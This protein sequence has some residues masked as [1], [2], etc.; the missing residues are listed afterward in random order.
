MGGRPPHRRFDDEL[1]NE[2]G[3]DFALALQR[4]RQTQPPEDGLWAA[5]ALLAKQISHFRHEVRESETRGQAAYSR[6][7]WRIAGDPDSQELGGAI[8]DIRD[9][10]RD[11]KAQI[12][13]FYNLGKAVLTAIASVGVIVA[14]GFISGHVRF[15]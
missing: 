9:D 4:L 10:L 3:D 7:H 14:A 12:Q 15:Q 6:L 5:V 2:T 11:L 1:P 13:S 8:G